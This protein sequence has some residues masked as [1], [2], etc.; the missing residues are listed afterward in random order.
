MPFESLGA[1]SYSPSI[2]TTAVSVA[3]CEL[4]S[5]KCKNRHLK[6]RDLE[7]SV[8]PVSYHFVNLYIDEIYGPWASALRLSKVSQGHRNLYFCITLYL[9]IYIYICLSYIVSEMVE[10]LRFFAVLI[11]FEALH[12]SGCSPV[13]Q[14]MTVCLTKL[15]CQC[16]T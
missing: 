5:V 6:Y 10:N 11:S 14:G 13:T 12:G 7:I 4:L 8:R 1:V 2:V 9:Y 3:V 16:Y 15:E